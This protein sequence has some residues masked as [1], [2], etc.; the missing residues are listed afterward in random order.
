MIKNG[1]GDGIDYK[2]TMNVPVHNKNKMYAVDDC[3]IFEW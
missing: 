1:F 2:M 3:K